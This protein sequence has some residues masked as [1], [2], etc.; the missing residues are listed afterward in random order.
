[1][2]Q[3]AANRSSTTPPEVSSLSSS[4]LAQLVCTQ[5]ATIDSL[6]SQVD[7]LKHQ[8]EWFKRQIFGSK[9]ERFAPEPDPN[10]LPLAAV[11]TT[12]D[13]TQAPPR[14]T[15]ITHTRR[16]RTQDPL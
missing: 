6:Q 2:S 11:S 5:S 10:Q 4:Q 14:Q 13:A 3:R 8:I 1:M 12:A 15:V 16:V 9:S 7:G